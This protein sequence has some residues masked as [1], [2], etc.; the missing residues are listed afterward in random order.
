M[1][2]LQPY[3][4]LNTVNEVA[5]T[6]VSPAEIVAVTRAP[7]G[8]STVVVRIDTPGAQYYL[9]IAHEHNASFYAEVEIHQRLHALGLHVPEV[10]FFESRNDLLQRSIMLTKAIPGRSI[11]HVNQPRSLESTVD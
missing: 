6:L 5:R 2:Q 10:V 4:D 11:G 1:T 7:E 9:R 3:E 8:K